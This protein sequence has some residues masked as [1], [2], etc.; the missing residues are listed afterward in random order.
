MCKLPLFSMVL[1]LKCTRYSVN[2]G[3][4]RVAYAPIEQVE[5]IEAEYGDTK[6]V[7]D[8][9]KEA[10]EIVQ[11]ERQVVAQALQGGGV[12]SGGAAVDSRP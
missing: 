10:K 7:A 4:Q 8:N 9:V 12:A 3:S 2:Q 11:Q 6:K 1:V 5:D